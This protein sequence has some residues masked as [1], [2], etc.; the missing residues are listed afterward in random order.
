MTAKTEAAPAADATTA[1]DYTYTFDATDRCDRCGAQ[2]YVA[3][4]FSKAVLLFC[5][6]HGNENQA[7]IADHIIGDEREKLQDQTPTPAAAR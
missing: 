7:M 1:D 4:A 5:A 2:A 6:H 3:A